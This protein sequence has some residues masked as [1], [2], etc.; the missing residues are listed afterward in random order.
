LLPHPPVRGFHLH[1]GAAVIGGARM[2]FTN[3]TAKNH[4]GGLHAEGAA[5]QQQRGNITFR[6]LGRKSMR[7]TI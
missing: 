1:G 7:F 2:T 6:N 4:G 5:V 3:C